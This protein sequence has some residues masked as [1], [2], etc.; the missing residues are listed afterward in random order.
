MF[1]T[2]RVAMVLA[3]ANLRIVKDDRDVEHRVAICGLVVDPF[4]ATLAREL[5]DDIAG[6]FFTEDNQ[7]RPELGRVVLNPRVPQQMVHLLTA[8]DMKTATAKIRYVDVLALAVN[9]EEDS[10]SGQRWLKCTVQIRFGMAEREHRE[11]LAARFGD[12]LW[13]TWSAEQMPLELEGK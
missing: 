12:K 6:H 8:P 13:W 1:R 11:L 7:I 2:D 3:K 9:V 10:K 5:G 4:E